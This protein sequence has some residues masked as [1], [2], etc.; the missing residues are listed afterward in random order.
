MKNRD[1][2]TF[3]LKRQNNGKYETW[4]Q[5]LFDT[6]AREEEALCGVD[7]SADDRIGV[8]Y[9]VDSRKNGLPVGTV[10]EGCKALAV[11]YAVNLIRDLEA[12]G[13]SPACRHTPPGDRPVDPCMRPFLHSAT[14]GTAPHRHGAS[15]DLV[16]RWPSPRLSATYTSAFQC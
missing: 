3:E 11:P 12:G 15:S 13:V 9:Y 4:E 5:H 14:C 1:D 6:D 2:W 8:D 7:T 10:C 16:N